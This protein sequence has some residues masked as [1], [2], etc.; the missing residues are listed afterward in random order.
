M[1]RIDVLDAELVIVVGGVA[2]DVC[3]KHAI[4]GFFARRDSVI[5]LTDDMSGLGL[6]TPMRS[7]RS[8]SGADSSR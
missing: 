7:S 1:S 5:L 6:K 8:G 3:V 4:D 2:T